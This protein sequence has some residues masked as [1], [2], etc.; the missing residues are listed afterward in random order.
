MITSS[1]VPNYDNWGWDTYWS[2][3]DWIQWHK[4][5]K[6]DF[7]LDHANLTFANAF[8]QAG[9]GAASYNCRT[10]NSAFRTYARDNGFL[11]SLYAGIGVIMEPAGDVLETGGNILGSAVSASEILKKLIPIV[12]VLAVIL[13]LVYFSKKAQLL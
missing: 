1:S 10:F 2:C 7:G 9:F 6:K 8:N 11:E 12:T 5:L 13:L 4:E 3:E